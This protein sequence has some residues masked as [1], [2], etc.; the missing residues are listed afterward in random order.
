M[1]FNKRIEKL[2][3]VWFARDVLFLRNH[4]GPKF[5]GHELTKQIILD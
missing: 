4:I 3:V 5:P 1:W 2:M